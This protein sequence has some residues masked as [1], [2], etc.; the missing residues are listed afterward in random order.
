[1]NFFNSGNKI[2]IGEDE[3]FFVSKYSP[4]LIFFMG[5]QTGLCIFAVIIYFMEVL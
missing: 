4:P 3:E 1:M 2:R 5:I